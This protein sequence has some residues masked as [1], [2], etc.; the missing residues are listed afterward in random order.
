MLKDTYNIQENKAPYTVGSQ[1]P[2]CACYTAKSRGCFE[3]V[4]PLKIV[5]GRRS[6]K[7]RSV[8]RQNWLRVQLKELV[9][10]YC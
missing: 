9:F 3:V 7:F 2:A 1:V 4:R 8:L 10:S 6:V 5:I